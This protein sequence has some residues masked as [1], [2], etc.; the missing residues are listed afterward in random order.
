MPIV[1]PK[2]EVL[3][4]LFLAH[5]PRSP[6]RGRRSALLEWAAQVPLA[7]AEVMIC[8]H[9]AK[10]SVE[11]QRPATALDPQDH[12]LCAGSELRFLNLLSGVMCAYF[13][14][15]WLTK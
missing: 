14:M 5:V 15:L 10:A 2:M 8:P 9:N 11:G 6:M 12:I 4:L 3:I 13:N 1:P 7:V